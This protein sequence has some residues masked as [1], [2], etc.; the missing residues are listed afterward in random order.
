MENL[1][2]FDIVGGRLVAIGRVPWELTGVRTFCTSHL[3]RFLGR[4]DASRS[5]LHPRDVVSP[6]LVSGQPKHWSSRG[7]AS[8]HLCLTP[9]RVVL[10]DDIPLQ[11]SCTSP[12]HRAG[13]YGLIRGI[14][15]PDCLGCCIG[16]PYDRDLLRP[17]HWSSQ[18]ATSNYARL[19]PRTFV[20]ARAIG[21]YRAPV[22]GGTR[23]RPA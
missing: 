2:S 8:S 20:P 5:D 11:H 13:L 18:R 21:P 19:R 3:Y 22:I 10:Q 23:H 15:A 9:G 17:G 12:V 4:A 6:I 1:R 16:C 7:D 14:S